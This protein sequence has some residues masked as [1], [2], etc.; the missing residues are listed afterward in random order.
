M[1]DYQSINPAQLMTPTGPWSHGLRI[2][3]GKEM[4]FDSGQ[5]GIG[6]DGVIPEGAEAQAELVW[7]NLG[8][9]LAAAGM[10]PKHIVRTGVYATSPEYLPIMNAV[11]NRFLGSARPATTVLV[12]PAL[13]NPKYLVEVDAIAAR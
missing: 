3:A 4:L 2:D 11:R 6:A 1:S 8:A 10:E 9:V 12:V 13:A 5:D 7:A